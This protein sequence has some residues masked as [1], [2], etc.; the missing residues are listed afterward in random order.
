MFLA[1]IAA[2]YLT[3]SVCWSVRLNEFQRVLNASKVTGRIMFQCIIHD[4]ICLVHI[5]QN[6]NALCIMHSIHRKYQM[7]K[8]VTQ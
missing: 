5:M 1:A 4:K 8:N 7:H 2:L 3:M 6:A